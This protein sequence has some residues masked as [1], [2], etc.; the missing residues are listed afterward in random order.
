[1]IKCPFCK[2]TSDE[3]NVCSGF[4]WF[5]PDD[6][7]DSLSDDICEYDTNFAPK[8]VSLEKAIEQNPFQALSIL[9]EWFDKTSRELSDVTGSYV[10]YRDIAGL[11]IECKVYLQQLDM[12]ER[13]ISGENDPTCLVTMWESL[14]R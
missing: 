14:Y 5:I 12:Y 1:M 13:A 6:P 11:L 10:F 9:T 2:Y 3:C 7:A 8:S 4:G